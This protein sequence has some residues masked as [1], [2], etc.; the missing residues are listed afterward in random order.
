MKAKFAGLVLLMGISAI[1][2]A[3]TFAHEAWHD[4]VIAFGP[5]NH[6]VKFWHGKPEI[7]HPEHHCKHGCNGGG[8]SPTPV[9]EPETYAMLLAGISLITAI[10]RRRRTG[11]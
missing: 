6:V 2:R 8:G 10:A 3:G 1:A 9:P 5:E 7:E 4:P 11:K